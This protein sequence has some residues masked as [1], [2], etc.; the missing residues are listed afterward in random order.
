MDKS[1]LFNMFIELFMTNYV[2]LKIICVSGVSTG[3]VSITILSDNEDEFD[4]T[5]ELN[6]VDPSGGKIGTTNQMIITI[7]DDDDDDDAVVPTP[8]RSSGGRYYVL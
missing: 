5:F 3:T 4:E 6:L 1:T 8:R 7:L 2:C